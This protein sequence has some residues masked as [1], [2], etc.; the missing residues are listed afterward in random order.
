MIAPLGLSYLP[1]QVEGIKFALERK[2]ILLGDEMRLG[3]TIQTAGVINEGEALDRI[4]VICPAHLKFDWRAKLKDWLLLPMG[5]GIS[6]GKDPWP[7]TDIVI[8]NYDI[9]DRF[10]TEIR[11]TQ[12]DLI[13]ADEA[14]YL[15][16]T[17]AKRTKFVLGAKGLKARQRMFL[18]GTPLVNRPVDLWSLANSLDPVHFRNYRT[19]VFRYCD[20]YERRIHMKRRGSCCTQCKHY[21]SNCAQKGINA[22][23]NPPVELCNECIKYCKRGYCRRILDVSGASNLVELSNK[24]QSFMLRRTRAEVQSDLPPVFREI[25]LLDGSEFASKSEKKFKQEHKD[26]KSRVAELDPGD[27]LY[28]ESMSLARH[29]L[30]LAKVPEVIEHLKNCIESSGKV[31]CFAHHRDVIDAIT[32]EFP[33]TSVKY[34]GKM[35]DTAKDK[36][37]RKF[38]SDPS[39]TL[40]VGNIISAGT[41]LDLSISSHVVMAELDWVPG[42]MDQDE[43]RCENL[44]KKEALLVQH[45]VVDGSLD[46]YIAKALVK[47]QNIIDTVTKN[48]RR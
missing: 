39:I 8:I 28:F 19:F 37:L 12:W 43:K 24:V 2:H 32:K 47:K 33:K 20:A 40:F 29:E 7:N 18:T 36:N 48:T 44:F 26:W 9:L 35:S 30:A 45:L 17:T 14:H 31:V 10:E 21:K 22:F 11:S 6:R 27:E 46:A 5:I 38:Q 42:N 13:V 15:K 41:G 23:G 4:L 16:S 34:Y 1:H 25:I 3:K